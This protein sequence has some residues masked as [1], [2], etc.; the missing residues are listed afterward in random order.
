MPVRMAEARWNGTL[1][2]GNGTLRLREGEMQLPYSF[3][4]RFEEGVGSNPEELIGAAH[5]GCFSMEFAN[6]LSSAGY[7]PAYVFT[8][9]R[10]M[11]EKQEAGFTVTKIALQTIAGVP[12][13]DN[14]TFQQIARAAK[15]SC[16]I[17]RLLQS[18]AEIT[19]EACWEEVEQAA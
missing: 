5:A 15:D 13:I 12:R 11:F 9:A 7:T 3:T 14:A 17:S 19:L 10:V 6:Q 16:P 18:E 4:S 2:E 1:R 8:T